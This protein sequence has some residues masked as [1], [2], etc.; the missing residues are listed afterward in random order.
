M[1]SVVHVGEAT[2]AKRLT[3]FTAT[4]A[5]DLTADEFQVRPG[6][7]V[8]MRGGRSCRQEEE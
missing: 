8:A 1:V 4:G 5:G 2:L 3:E 7:T 6:E